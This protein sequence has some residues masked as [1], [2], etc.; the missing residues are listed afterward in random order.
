MPQSKLLDWIKTSTCM[1]LSILVKCKSR[2]QLHHYN[3]R[4][5]WFMFLPLAYPFS[6][7]TLVRW[8]ERMSQWH[9]PN[10]FKPEDKVCLYRTRGPRDMLVRHEYG[11][12]LGEPIEMNFDGHQFPIIPHY[13]EFLRVWYGDYMQIPQLPENLGRVADCDF[14]DN[15]VKI[16]K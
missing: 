6:M 12:L 14:Y 2:I 13:D 5:L 3:R 4:K 9:N 16:I 7:Q 11:L 8:K 1:L 15:K 10:Q